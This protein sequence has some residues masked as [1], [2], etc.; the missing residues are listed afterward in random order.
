MKDIVVKALI[1]Y[2]LRRATSLATLRYAVMVFS[3]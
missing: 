1:S 2:Y 3:S